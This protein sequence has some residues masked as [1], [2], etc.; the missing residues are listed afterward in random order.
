MRNAPNVEGGPAGGTV[1]ISGQRL[2]VLRSLVL[3]PRGVPARLLKAELGG[4]KS[5]ASEV[6]R[7]RDAIGD[8][9]KSI[10]HTESIR[11][12]PGYRLCLLDTDVV[13]AFLFEKAAQEYGLNDG[14]FEK[15]PVGYG[16]N[17]EAV[18][19][20]CELMSANPGRPES[21]INAVRN[22][23]QVYDRYLWNLQLATA[24]GYIRRWLDGGVELDVTTGIAYLK[25][26]VVGEGTPDEIWRMLIRVE[27]SLANWKVQLPDLERQIADAHDGAVPP[28]YQQLLRLCGP[29]RDAK[30]IFE[31]ASS[32]GPVVH[33]TDTIPAPELT[34]KD[35]G[36]LAD[37]AVR[38]GISSNAALRLR[39]SRV[40]PSECIDMT[41]NRL[42][43]AGLF[44]GKW[45]LDPVVRAKFDLLLDKL[46]TGEDADNVVGKPVR[47]L[48]L[49]P[50][51]R[52]FEGL[53]RLGMVTGSTGIRSIPILR[54][55]VKRHPSFAVH[56]YDSMP[57]FRMVI[58]DDCLV[59]VAP[60]LNVPA[61]FSLDGGWDVPHL[62]LTPAAQYPLAKSFET[63]FRYLWRRS[64]PIEHLS[65]H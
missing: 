54:D 14:D 51:S 15:L 43:F 40:E 55:L 45:T 13:D 16:S 42:W 61:E 56:M 5:V 2:C 38:L 60:Y 19:E 50:S 35:R 12:E 6:L 33:G 30:W 18:R 64:R 53:K 1:L 17:V 8:K 48:I 37:V 39:N 41:V 21:H 20:A 59:T 7:L 11:G 49:D 22:A 28:E 46:D 32:S 63:L 26:L 47:L 65:G 31:P 4:V 23:D 62:V 34:I 3:E 29:R 58:I 24:Y 36:N 27:G 10:I 44:A 52:A 9:A 25:R 57:M